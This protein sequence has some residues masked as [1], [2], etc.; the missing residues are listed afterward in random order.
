M[1]I[2]NTSFRLSDVFHKFSNTK[3][4][5]L[6]YVKCFLKKEKAEYYVLN[7]LEKIK[8]EISDFEIETGFIDSSIKNFTEDKHNRSLNNFKG[9][10][11]AVSSEEK[12]KQLI[13]IIREGKI[14]IDEDILS[15]IKVMKFEDKN[16]FSLLITVK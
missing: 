9:L 12:L 11:I 4:N 3:T 8:K 14:G 2:E 13:D 10:I 15:E 7:V 16:K 5:T 6:N 1:I